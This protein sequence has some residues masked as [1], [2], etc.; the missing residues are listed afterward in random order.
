V[1]EVYQ[2]GDAGFA[3]TASARVR[4]SGLQHEEAAL[5]QLLARHARASLPRSA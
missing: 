5:V 3:D 1:F 2:E 4:R